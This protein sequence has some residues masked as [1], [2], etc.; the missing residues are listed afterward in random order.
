MSPRK[1]QPY[2][3][4]TDTLAK[5]TRLIVLGAGKPH[6]LSEMESQAYDELAADIAADRAKGYT[7]EIPP[8]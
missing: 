2:S 8:E 7:T 5:W 4:D 3:P 1:P 6:G